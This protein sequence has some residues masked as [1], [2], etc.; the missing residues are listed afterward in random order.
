M[1]VQP[2]PEWHDVLSSMATGRFRSK[3]ALSYNRAYLVLG[4]SW[5]ARSVLYGQVAHCH[6][7]DDD[8]NLF[9]APLGI[10]SILDPTVPANWMAKSG[11][12]S[13]FLWPGLFYR[14]FFFDDL[15]EGVSEVVTEFRDLKVGMERSVATGAPSI[16]VD[17]GNRD[18]DGHVRL[19]ATGAIHDLRSRS[20]EL[21]DGLILRLHDGDISASAVARPPGEEQVWRAELLHHPVEDSRWQ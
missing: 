8:G 3:L 10:F 13:V 16:S 2:L 21:I 15:S 6:L 11:E 4:L 17:F 12:G 18:V 20:V 5:P 9:A 14:E 1:L 19:N 7:V